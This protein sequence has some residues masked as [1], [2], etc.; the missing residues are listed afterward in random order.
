MREQDRKRIWKT[1]DQDSRRIGGDREMREQNRNRI[2][3]GRIGNEGK[4]K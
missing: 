2:R 3:K 1:R 4:G